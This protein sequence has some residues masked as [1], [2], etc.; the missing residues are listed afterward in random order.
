MAEKVTDVVSGK[1]ETTVTEQTTSEKEKSVS[2]T[3]Q[4]KMKPLITTEDPSALY[5]DALNEHNIN[6]VADGS[7]TAIVVLVGFEEYG[8]S[9]FASSLYHCFFSKEQYCG[10]IMYDSET[11]SG[12]ERRLLVRS[13]KK[14]DPHLKNKRTIKGE[15][16]LL[17]LLLD[18]EKT[19]KYKVVI[20]DRSGEDYSQFAGT[21]EEINDNQIL[22]VADHIVFFIDCEKLMNNFAMLRYSYQNFLQELVKGNLLPKNGQIKLVFNK[23]DL[24][25]DNPDYEGKRSQAEEVFKKVLGDRTFD[26]Y[27]IDSTGVSDN[28]VSVEKLVKSFLHNEENK[29]RERIEILDWVKKELSD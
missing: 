7:E 26:R 16:P 28:F 17:V 10:H 29:R 20:S 8:K 4:M 9:T 15:D 3:E 11:Y 22:K 19:G 1:I 14:T 21:E 25:K 12:F 6:Q 5:C 18:S 2:Q 27:E 24:V 13:M 23:H